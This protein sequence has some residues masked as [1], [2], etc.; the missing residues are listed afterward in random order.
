MREHQR[1]GLLSSP[2]ARDRR[3]VQ[4]YDCV[5]AGWPKGYIAKALGTSPKQVRDW[6]L[7]A[8]HYGVRRRYELRLEVLRDRK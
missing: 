1:A 3:N 8:E 6:C 4:V 7:R 5:A 2:E